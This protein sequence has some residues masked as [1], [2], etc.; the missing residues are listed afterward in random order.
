VAAKLS[1]HLPDQAVRIQVLAD[2]AEMV[3]GRDTES[4]IALR[5]A[6]VSRRHALLK[7]LGDGR[8]Q[9][10][11]LGSKNGTRVNG[12]RIDQTLIEPGR[13]FAIGDVYCEFEIIDDAAL[14]QLQRRGGERRDASAAWSRRLQDDTDL[15]QLLGD[16]L[17]G[18]VQ[19]AEC[20]RGFLLTPD[21]SGQLQISACFALQPGQLASPAFLGSRSA[22]DRVLDERRPVY[23]SD[24]RDRLWLKDQASVIDQG[25]HALACLPMLHQGELLGVAYA[26]TADEARVFTDLDAEVLAALVD[27]ACS[28]LAARRLAAQLAQLSAWVAVD[29]QGITRMSAAPSTWTRLRN[30]ADLPR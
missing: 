2:G 25:I 11:D 10:Q 8:W 13:W 7:D 9:L 1:I 23:M 14:V 12:T 5:H 15:Q 3:L 4:A 19:V 22:V 17:T 16:L 6:S 21:G 30:N 20:Q 24:R 18:I 26:D 28:T 27:H 29:A